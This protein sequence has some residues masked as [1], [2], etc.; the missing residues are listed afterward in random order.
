M[1]KHKSVLLQKIVEV[2]NPKN[3]GVF[4][5]ATLGGGGHTLGLISKFEGL[6]SNLTIICFDQDEEAIRNFEN[7]LIEIGFIKEGK[8]FSKNNIKVSLVNSNFE[9]LKQSLEELEIKEIDGFIADLGFSTDQ[10]EDYPRGFSFLQQG[11][12]DMRMDKKSGVKAKDLLN[13]LYKTELEKL[14]KEFGDLTWEAKK[15]AE[16]VLRFL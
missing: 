15:I 10:L 6:N 12:L 8:W 13:G 3:G 9:N 14:F 11:D 2:L 4:V 16:G 5:D 7:K 1:T